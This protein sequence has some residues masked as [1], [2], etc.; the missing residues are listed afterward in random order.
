MTGFTIRFG[1]YDRRSWL[2]CGLM[3]L[4]SLLTVVATPAKVTLV[5]R[6]DIDLE[7]MVPQ[8]IGDWHIDPNV[9]PLQLSPEMQKGLNE[10]YSQTLARTYVNQAGD[11]VMLSLAYGGDQS[12][13]LSLHKPEHCY[14]AQGFEIS[15]FN[16]DN[17]RFADGDFP[18]TR[19]LAVR[20]QRS[21]P[22]T[23]W[24]TV[25]DK[26]VRNGVDQ[27][28]QKLRYAMTGKIP[29]GLLLRVSTIDSDEEHAYHIED[30]FIRAMLDA[31]QPN[32]R[33]RVTGMAR[34]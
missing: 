6:A 5:R 23:Y 8:Q 29:D 30:A 24:T 4:T 7:K 11:L 26:V 13:N 9:A 12:G 21:E 18:V 25:G 2:I 3:L 31:M 34:L 14:G 20:G 22:I 17:F 27:K 15:H 32:D 10:L 1:T 16:R 19:L 33:A 28:L